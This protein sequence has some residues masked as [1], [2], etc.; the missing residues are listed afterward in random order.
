MENGAND[1]GKVYAEIGRGKQVRSW[2][3]EKDKVIAELKAENER[4]RME[5]H[6]YILPSQLRKERKEVLEFVKNTIEFCKG[7]WVAEEFYDLAKNLL[8]K[9]EA[10]NKQF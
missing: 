6:G 3:N 4:L 5:L 8:K 7:E 9:L 1:Q 10:D 2:L